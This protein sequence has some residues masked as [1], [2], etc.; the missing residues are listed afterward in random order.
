MSTRNDLVRKHYTQI[1]G[2]ISEVEINKLRDM[3]R[4]KVCLEI[5]GQLGKE[6]VILA[7]TARKVVVVVS[8][9]NIDALRENIK[10]YGNIEI[11]IG[12]I[13]E[14]AAGLQSEFFDLIYADNYKQADYFASKLK[15]D[16]VLIARGVI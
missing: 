9:D 3:A 11:Y 6:T 16:G 10:G 1:P 13:Y 14:T 15:K 8:E 4:G 5:N 12:D 2:E 7:Q